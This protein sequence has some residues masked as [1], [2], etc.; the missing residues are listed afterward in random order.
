MKPNANREIILTISEK[1]FSCIRQCHQGKRQEKRKYIYFNQLLFLL[2]T[3]PEP[4]TSGNISPPPSVNESE[5]HI[6]TTGNQVGERSHASNVTYRQQKKCS[7][8]HM[9]NIY[10]KYLKK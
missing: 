5:V 3:M 7:K 9:R 10:W 4:D 1:N 8:Q 6:I 2:P